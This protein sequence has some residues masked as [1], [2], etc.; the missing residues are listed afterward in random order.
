[1]QLNLNS[2]SP[3]GAEAYFQ[4]MGV[5]SQK[6]RMRVNH[7]KFSKSMGINFIVCIVFYSKLYSKII[8]KYEKF[9]NEWGSITP[10]H[11]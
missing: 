4:F 3:P 1:M 8:S 7:I 10:I 9:E 6:F 5:K 11:F 2:V